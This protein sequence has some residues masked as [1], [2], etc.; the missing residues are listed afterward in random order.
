MKNLKQTLANNKALIASMISGAG[1]A[2]SSGMVHAA[3]D[4]S[5]ATNG[6]L[7]TTSL[8]ENLFS[9]LTTIVPAM[10]V[11]GVGFWVVRFGYKKIAGKAH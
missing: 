5:I 4:A 10:V 2:L 11:V 6:A 1:L 7:V 3:A 9:G 8:Q